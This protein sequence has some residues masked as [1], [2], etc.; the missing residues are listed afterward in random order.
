MNQTR[1]RE[2]LE[3][4]LKR[5][6]TRFIEADRRRQGCN[7]RT[8][9]N[10][11][12]D[13]RQTTTTTTKTAVGT[14]AQG[15]PSSVVT[16]QSHDDGWH[17]RA[18]KPTRPEWKLKSSI[19]DLDRRRDFSSEVSSPSRA[20]RH[21]ASAVVF[22]IGEIPRI[23]RNPRSSVPKRMP[24]T[25]RRKE[26]QKSTPPLRDRRPRPTRKQTALTSSTI[27]QPGEA[28]TLGRRKALMLHPRVFRRDELL[29]PQAHLALF[30][31]PSYF[32]EPERPPFYN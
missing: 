6:L 29:F 28:S 13:R 30:Q 22:I 11:G 18:C 5:P 12:E 31:C 8:T 1:H 2:A 17:V 32:R 15:Q 27:N 21:F 14:G 25:P 16:L 7:T 20:R 24:R 26:K 4:C 23:L 3:H 19:P 10:E 9:T